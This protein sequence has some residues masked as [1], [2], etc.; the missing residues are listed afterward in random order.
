LDP[1]VGLERI[2]ERGYAKT[3]FDAESLAFHARVR[4][5][6][7]QHVGDFGPHAVIDASGSIEEVWAETKK[8][9]EPFLK[10]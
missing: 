6:Y 8:A 5:G 3:R 1:K 9:L 10:Q 7:L 4:E 2:E